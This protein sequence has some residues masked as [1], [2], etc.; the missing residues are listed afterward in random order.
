MDSIIY[1]CIYDIIDFIHSEIGNV[2]DI[3]SYRLLTLV[4]TLVYLSSSRLTCI[5]YG[6]YLFL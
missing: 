1:I 5:L 4:A 3:G 2:H 6:I